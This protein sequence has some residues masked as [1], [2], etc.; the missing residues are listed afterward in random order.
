MNTYL[1]NR[2]CLSQ[3]NKQLIQLWVLWISLQ[4]E[5]H[6]SNDELRINILAWHLLTVALRV[7]T[8]WHYYSLNAISVASSWVFS[9][10]GGLGILLAKGWN[11]N[12]LLLLQIWTKQC[13]CVEWPIII[14]YLHGYIVTSNQHIPLCQVSDPGWLIVLLLRTP[15]LR[16]Q[17]YNDRKDTNE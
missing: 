1:L 9:E 16:A 11:T 8:Q 14:S 6:V 4:K 5:R 12:G 10:A 7:H 2:C 3:W 17:L 13:Q 15:L